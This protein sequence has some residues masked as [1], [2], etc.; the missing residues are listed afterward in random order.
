MWEA[1]QAILAAIRRLYRPEGAFRQV[2]LL[3]AAQW[4]RLRLPPGSTWQWYPTVGGCQM[5]LSY[6]DQAT[7]ALETLPAVGPSVRH[8]HPGRD[9]FVEFSGPI[10][11]TVWVTISATAGHKVGQE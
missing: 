2:P 8:V 5:R 3:G 10:G 4:A 6:G 7:P 11:A 9:V 1:A